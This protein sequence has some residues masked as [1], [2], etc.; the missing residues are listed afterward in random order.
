VVATIQAAIVGFWLADGLLEMKW[1]A[2]DWAGSVIFAT[3]DSYFALVTVHYE[4]RVPMSRSYD[5]TGGTMNSSIVRRSVVIAATRRASALKTSPDGFQ[6]NRRISTHDGVGF[7]G[8]RR[9]RSAAR[10]PLVSHP[11]LCAGLLSRAIR[12]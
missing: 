3:P 2:P 11:P 5:D 8:S 10:K 1:G 4:L 12:R 7:A 6:T 9:L